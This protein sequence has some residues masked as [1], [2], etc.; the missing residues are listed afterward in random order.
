MCDPG[1]ECG[2]LLMLLAWPALSLSALT[3]PL[4]LSA[5]QV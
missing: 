1:H 2:D 5:R 3:T 4:L